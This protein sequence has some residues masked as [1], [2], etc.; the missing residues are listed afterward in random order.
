MSLDFL[1]LSAASLF[2]EL[3]LIRYLSAEIRIFAYFSNLVLVTCFLG[4]GLGYALKRPRFSLAV[5]FVATALLVLCCQSW[6]STHVLPFR[7]ISEFL[8]FGDL[9]TWS[10][11]ESA[12]WRTAVGV[13]LLL[14]LLVQVVAVFV[15][16]G[17]ALGEAFDRAAS[18]DRLPLYSG[19]V[20]ASLFGILAFQ[21]VAA[22]WLP[23]AA[24]LTVGLGLLLFVLR[25]QPLALLVSI[26]ALV[27]SVWFAS[28][29]ERADRKLFWSPYQKLAL[30]TVVHVEP[31]EGNKPEVTPFLALEVNSTIYQYL[32][33]FRAETTASRPRTFP[34]AEGPFFYYEL[35]YRFVPRPK[36]VLVV[37]AGTGNDVA[38]A[39]RNGAE[40][41]DAVEIDPTILAIGRAVHPENPYGDPRVQTIVDD[42][43]SHFN[44]TDR[45]YDLILFGLLDSH[46]LTSNFSN[47]SLDSYVYTLES[48]RAA[49][50]LLTDDGIMVVSFQVAR[51]FLGQ[52][53]H[54]TLAQIFG[55]PPL[56]LNFPQLAAVQGTGGTLFVSGDRGRIAEALDRVPQLAS[57]RIALPGPPV[58]PASDDWPYIYV[59]RRSIPVLWRIVSLAVIGCVLLSLLPIGVRAR[60]LDPSCFFLGFAF[61]LL[62]THTISRFALAFG[63]TWTV[64]AAV[65]AGVLVMIL[66][67]NAVVSRTS[68][69][70]SLG[71]FVALAV[72]AT[73]GAF[74][75]V[76]RFAASPL[77]V[78]GLALVVL[79]APIFFAAIAFA[80]AFDSAADARGALLSNL[81]GAVVGGLAQSLSF[82]TGQ[83]AL[84]VLIVAAY[85]TAWL[86]GAARRRVEAP[87][88]SRELT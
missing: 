43:R 8:A 32:L 36:S 51:A 13:A 1:A 34:P 76:D 27:A 17:Q 64:S 67:G 54:D 75:P 33:D 53:L 14:V 87:V 4:L 19:N 40:H 35:P 21:A 74:V 65:I 57:R 85:A 5:T 24:W 79:V 77:Y 10:D 29:A 62:E 18:K 52:R 48:F 12:L 45:R 23:P 56:I 86:T 3:L 84:V 31:V 26:A 39:L 30:Q 82:V 70:A 83:R 59:E 22:M 88:D 16:L 60:H 78:Q 71:L 20:A 50:S 68:L 55:E 44:R 11:T 25:R 38:A 42:A 9:N 72:T 37:G 41:I 58:E 7:G 49:R 80:R 69:R 73:V 6:V 66:A 61:M 63:A 28:P 46:R 2:I 47:T 15:P 81:L